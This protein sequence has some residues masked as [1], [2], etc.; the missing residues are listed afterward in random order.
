MPTL[1]RLCLASLLVLTHTSALA[2]TYVIVIEN[3]RYAPASLALKRGDRVVWENRD[4]FPHTATADTNAFDSDDLPSQQSW[5]WDAEKPGDYAYH[6]A[7]HP[8]MT[9]RLIVR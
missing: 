6:C 2:D 7:Y 5:T 8:M 3:M 4:L 9:A 1:M